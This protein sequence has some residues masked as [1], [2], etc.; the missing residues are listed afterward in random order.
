MEPKVLLWRPKEIWQQEQ[1]STALTLCQL[2]NFDPQKL[3]Q[4]GSYV[5]HFGL[6]KK[7]LLKF[8]HYKCAKNGRSLEDRGIPNAMDDLV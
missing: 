8:L 7:V 3:S 4:F 6:S 2:V 5:C 1:V